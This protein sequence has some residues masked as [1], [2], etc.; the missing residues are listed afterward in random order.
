MRTGKAPGLQ[1]ALRVVCALTVLVAASSHAWDEAATRTGARCTSDSECAYEAYEA[2]EH[3]LRQAVLEAKGAPTDST[4]PFTTRSS[5]CVQ[6]INS[7]HP[8]HVS[9]MACAT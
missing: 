8:P 9:G 5:G 7:P 1:D 2:C 6:L 4:R 3:C